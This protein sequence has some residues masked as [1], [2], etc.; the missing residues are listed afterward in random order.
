[1]R[2]DRHKV[3]LPA[4]FPSKARAV[5]LPLA[6]DWT[7]CPT[8]DKAVAVLVELNASARQP[9]FMAIEHVHV[10]TEHTKAPR[11]SLCEDLMS[12]CHPMRQ[13]L[14]CWPPPCSTGGTLQFEILV[15][16]AP[17]NDGPIVV[18]NFMTGTVT[19]AEAPVL[20]DVA[21]R[22]KLRQ[23]THCNFWAD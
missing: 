16:Q 10:L 2:D 3:R 13:G 6:A 9:E 22:T 12:P 19:R 18:R 15:Q 7:C 11:C 20:V 1:M 23:L 14:P 5:L 17:P 21:L 4:A 8:I